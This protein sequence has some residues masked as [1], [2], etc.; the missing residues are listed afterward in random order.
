MGLKHNYFNGEIVLAS[1]ITL[2]QQFFLRNVKI[3]FINDSYKL[4]I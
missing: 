2:V 3:A 1:K 4:F